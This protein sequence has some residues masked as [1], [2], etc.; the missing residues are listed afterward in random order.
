MELKRL[1]TRFA[2]RIEPN[3]GGGFIARAS[4]PSAPV[5]T[6]PT[7]E[8]LQQKI[9]Q[10]I[11]DGLAQAFP[12]LKLPEGTKREFAFHV[13]HTPAGGFEIHS[14]DPK[15][16]VIQTNSRQEFE[17]RF[18]EK[19][20]GFAGKL[21]PELSNALA[22]ANV[23]DVKVVVNTKTAFSVNPASRKVTIGAPQSFAMG[24]AQAQQEAQVVTLNGVAA[25]VDNS[26]ITP[27]KSNF[28]N[29][30]LRLL[31]GFLILAAIVYLILHQLRF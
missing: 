20:L 18:L 7:R 26:P 17:S 15:I 19:M 29:I 21:S 27:E 13:E 23:G 2:Y 24:A 14:A 4:D 6:A 1:I 28:A 3:P 10:N 8:E 5:L 11:V 31:L 22:K 30:F 9:Q 16:G 12:G 25:P